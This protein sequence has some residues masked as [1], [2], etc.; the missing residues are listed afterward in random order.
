MDWLKLP[1]TVFYFRFSR[2]DWRDNRRHGS[3]SVRKIVWLR[4]VFGEGESGKQVFNDGVRIEK[5]VHISLKT[6]SR[7]QNLCNL[8]ALIASRTSSSCSKNVF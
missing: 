4:A 8:I 6:H 3:R 2:S 1:R 7:L 5:M